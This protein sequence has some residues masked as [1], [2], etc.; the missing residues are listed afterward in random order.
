MPGYCVFSY[1]L[2]DYMPVVRLDKVAAGHW[3][4]LWHITEDEANLLQQVHDHG[5]S[6]HQINGRHPQKRI[7]S[8]AGRLAIRALTTAAE[9]P[10]SDIVKDKHNKPH[11]ANGNGHIS[12]SHSWPYAIAALHL[13]HPAGIDI[14]VVQERMVRIMPRLLSAKEQQHAQAD[15]ELHCLYW[16]AKEAVY[17][18]YGRRNL[19]FKQNIEVAPFEKDTTGY[20]DAALVVDGHRHPLQLAFEKMNDY[21]ICYTT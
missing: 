18:W 11:L 4:C 1:S 2:P 6:T 14:E 9:Q 7:E 3:L 10:A 21:Y 12:M 20:I 5:I 17:K 8:L 16:A 13:Q 19:D 15:A